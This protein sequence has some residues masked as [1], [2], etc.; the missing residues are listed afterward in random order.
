MAGGKGCRVLPGSNRTNYL[1]SI[2]CSHAAGCRYDAQ[3]L[4]EPRA[5]GDQEL[6]R[7]AA[8]LTHHC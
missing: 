4:Q 2:T 6:Q 7:G 3:L 1:P 8:E 5:A